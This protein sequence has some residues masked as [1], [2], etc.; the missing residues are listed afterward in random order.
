[1][2]RLSALLPA[3]LLALALTVPARADVVW[4]PHK[5]TTALS[6]LVPTLL[7]IAAVAVTFLLIRKFR[8]K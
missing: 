8:K 2:K 7:V 4:I 5:V 6:Y 3:S 1:M